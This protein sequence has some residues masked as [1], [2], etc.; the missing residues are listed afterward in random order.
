M[1]DRLIELIKHVTSCEKCF[2][3]DIADYLLAN[4]VTL[5]PLKAG[6]K[7]YII[8][9]NKVKE[10]DV[11]FVGIS[12]DEKC[13]YFDFVEKYADGTFYKSY[14][15]VFDVIGKTVFLTKEEAKKALKERAGK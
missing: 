8:N 3:E 14:S 5:A 1:R 12:V 15:M 2:D 10:C 7:V 9:R 13:S 4:G 11:F 6:D